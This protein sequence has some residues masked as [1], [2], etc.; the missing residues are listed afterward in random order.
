MC[1]MILAAGK[2]ELGP[3]IDGLIRMAADINERHE[4]NVKPY[5]HGDGW[6]I[7]YVKDGK[8]KV[9]KSVKPCYYDSDIDKLR[10]VKTTLAVLHARKASFGMPIS[11]ENTHPFQNG[12]WV[13]CHN[14]SVWDKLDVN[15]RAKGNTDS[16]RLFYTMLQPMKKGKELEAITGSIDKLRRF[17]GL[18]VI[19]ASPDKAFAVIRFNRD[20]KYYTMKIG[21]KDGL[22]V[23][24]SETLRGAGMKWKPMANGDIVELNIRKE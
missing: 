3:L 8:W 2:V 14:G 11:M 17:T 23:V 22:T 6:G 19:L 16:E 9:V 10:K 18:N 20:E 24:S 12:R 21:Q 5:R 1:R 7:A 13:F 4:L 15:H